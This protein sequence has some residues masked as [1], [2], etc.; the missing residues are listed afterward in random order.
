MERENPHPFFRR[1]AR[2]IRGRGGLGSRG[3][4]GERNK[5]RSEKRGRSMEDPDHLRR[6]AARNNRLSAAHRQNLRG[7]TWVATTLWR[8]WSWTPPLTSITHLQLK[9]PACCGGAPASVQTDAWGV[10]L[11][12]YTPGHAGQPP[13]RV[14]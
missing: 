1:Q 2:R 10:P 14:T 6:L 7:Q 11:Y 8:W 9:N 3:V 12:R 5:N 4:L 13:H